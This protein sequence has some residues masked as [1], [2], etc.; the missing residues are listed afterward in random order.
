LGNC[1]FFLFKFINFLDGASAQAVAAAGYEFDCQDS[2]YI[3]EDLTYFHFEI[4]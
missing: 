3:I 4:K 1:F 2:F